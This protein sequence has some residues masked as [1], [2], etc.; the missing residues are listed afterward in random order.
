MK[1]PRIGDLIMHLAKL[2]NGYHWYGISRVSIECSEFSD[3]PPQ[4]ERWAEMRPYQRIGLEQYQKI[5]DPPHIESIF[6]KYEDVFRNILPYRNN[7][8]VEYGDEKELR[9]A[10]RYIG[11]VPVEIYDCFNDYSNLHN[12][13]PI[14]IQESHIPTDSEIPHPD[15]EAPGRT[16]TIVT[17]II[18]DTILIRELKNQFD[19]T[20]QICGYQIMLPNGNSYCEGHHL[21]PLGGINGG[22]D[23]KEN[24]ILLCP[25]HHAEFDYGSMAINTNDNKIVHLDKNNPLHGQPIAYERESSLNDYLDYHF[26]N[27]F[28]R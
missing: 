23:A 8:Y 15:F 22:P 2:E 14:F 4:P 28:N 21:H 26:G 24:I 20:C 9:V 25:T 5:V 11:I 3:S 18:R 12:F 6:N 19:S 1:E 27:R 13:N 16:E 7:F 17:R 10:Q